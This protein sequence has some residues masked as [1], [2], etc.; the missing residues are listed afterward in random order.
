[1]VDIRNGVK[2]CDQ[3]M[4]G[5]AVGALSPARQAIMACQREISVDVDREISFQETL[6]AS[7]MLEGEGVS[8]SE[9]FFDGLPE[10]LND[11][12]EDEA[13]RDVSARSETAEITANTPQTLKR[14]CGGEL[15][16]LKWRKLVPGVAAYDIIGNRKS[17]TDERLFLLKVKGGRKIP[18]HAHTGEEW[19]LIVQGSYHSGDE[20]YKRGDLDMS[21]GE[22]MH[23]PRADEGEDCICLVMIE[24]PL[25]MKGLALR[26]LQPLVGI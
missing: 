21:D 9:S 23:E 26:L 2:T 24:G 12:L 18:E 11:S 25:Q 19:A 7:L 14:L 4:H 20:A 5:F 22:D 16:E 13:E 1:M 8:L 3:A 6:A 15:S 17:K 10:R